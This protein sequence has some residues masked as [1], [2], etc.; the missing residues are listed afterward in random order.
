MKAAQRLNQQEI[1]GEPDWA[2]PVGVAAE[3]SSSR[4]RGLIV[5]LVVCSGNIQHVRMRFVIARKR[6]DAVWRKELFFIEHDGKNA[7]ELIAVRNGKQAALLVARGLH[8]GDVLGKVFAIFNE[9]LQ[10]HLESWHGIK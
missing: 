1:Y 2:A 3:Q 6:A 10:P 9:P 5:N 4:F 8:A 7:L